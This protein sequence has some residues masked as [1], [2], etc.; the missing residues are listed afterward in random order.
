MHSCKDCHH[1]KYTYDNTSKEYRCDI[2]GGKTFNIPILH[3]FTCKNFEDNYSIT[4]LDTKDHKVEDISL[5]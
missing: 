2:A 4:V 3:G 1:C 5:K